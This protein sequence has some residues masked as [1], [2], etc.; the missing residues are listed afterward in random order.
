MLV[1]IR[2]CEIKIAGRL[3]ESPAARLLR[4]CAVPSGDCSGCSLGRRSNFDTNLLDEQCRPVQCVHVEK[5]KCCE[6]S[7]KASG[8][9]SMQG[10]GDAA[11]SSTT[12]STW[13][14][15]DFSQST[16][17]N[18][19]KYKPSLEISSVLNPTE[20]DELGVLTQLNRIR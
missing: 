5:R 19:T 13:H 8:E 11:P 10:E 12:S 14:C 1:T 15:S 2:D 18:Q 7:A 16:Q 20:S 4:S 17:P 9:R 3:R 6:P